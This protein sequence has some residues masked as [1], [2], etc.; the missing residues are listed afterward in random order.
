MQVVVLRMCAHARARREERTVVASSTR[1][2]AVD[3]SWDER[4]KKL[5]IRE[6][7]FRTEGKRRWEESVKSGEASRRLY[8]EVSDLKRKIDGW[9]REEEEFHRKKRMKWDK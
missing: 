1:W 3:W 6:R 5:R 8:R 9:E 4:V 7:E 2:S